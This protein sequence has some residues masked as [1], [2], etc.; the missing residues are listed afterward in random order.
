MF[1]D[2]PA[3]AYYYDEL[4]TAKQLGIAA[5]TGDGAFQPAAP[6]T[7]QD[8]MVLTV[9]ALEAAGRSLP[10][11]SPLTAYA[12]ADLVADYAKDSV[13]AL[14]ASGI[15]AGKSGNRIAPQDHLTRAEAAVIL[16]R[17]W[18]E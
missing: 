11:G 17:I 3:S 8:M 18:K 6:I 16:Y 12:D 7:R 13:T 14:A 1:R 4:R 10:S 2:V 15:I 5:G 9:R